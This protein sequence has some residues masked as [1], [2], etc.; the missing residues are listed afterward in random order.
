MGSKGYRGL[1]G[2]GSPDEVV[3][4]VAAGSRGP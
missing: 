3:E 4:G 1:G 2:Q